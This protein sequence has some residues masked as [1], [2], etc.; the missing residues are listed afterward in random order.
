MSAYVSC[1]AYT[2]AVIRQRMLANLCICAG[3]VI[4]AMAGAALAVLLWCL[5][6]QHKT[7]YST[8][9]YTSLTSSKSLTQSRWSSQHRRSAYASTM[10]EPRL[11][12]DKLSNVLADCQLTLADGGI[13]SRSS[14]DYTSAT[15][16]HDVSSNSSVQMITAQAQSSAGSTAFYSS[17]PVITDLSNFAPLSCPSFL[18]V[19]QKLIIPAPL[20]QDVEIAPENISIAQ[21]AAGKDWILGQGSYGMVRHLTYSFCS[22]LGFKVRQERTRQHLTLTV[23]A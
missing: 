19:Q 16:A 8:K 6:W 18:P 9:P 12:T 15:K 17:R 10:L 22:V 21:T 1:I 7:A 3:S 11:S 2:W 5:I 4:A 23:Q 20:W 13:T 14:F